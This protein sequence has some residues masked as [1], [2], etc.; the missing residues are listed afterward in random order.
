MHRWLGLLLF[1]A[2]SPACEYVETRRIDMCL[3]KYE[4]C[5]QTPLGRPRPGGSICQTCLN[6]CN[7]LGAWPNENF[8][9]EPC[10]YYGTGDEDDIITIDH[11][12]SAFSVD[13]GLQP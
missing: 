8:A 11:A 9:G 1:L 4:D 7:M 2:W 12:S 13:A 5:Q 6:I 10:Y 3:I